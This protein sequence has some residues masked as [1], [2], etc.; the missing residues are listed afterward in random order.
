MSEDSHTE[1]QTTKKNT[2]KE[3]KAEMSFLDHLEA[4]R[5]HFIRSVI[6][7]FVFAIAAFIYKDFIF[8]SIIFAP[9]NPDFWTNRMF[10]LLADYVGVE[11]LKINSHEL[12]LISIAMSGQFMVHIWTA[13]VVGLIVASPFVI[14]QFWSFIK[15]ALYENER[16]HATGAV[17]YMSGLFIMG[18]LFGYYL[19][20]PLSID[21]LGAYSISDTVVNQINILSYISTVTSIVIAGGVVF[22]LPVIAFFLSK[23]GILTPGFMRKYR[24]HAIVVL[25]LVSAVITPP[26]VFSQIM[27]CIPLL[28][29][30]E[31]S[32]VISARVQ[33]A[34]ERRIDQI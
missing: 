17:I 14:Y 24:K 28:I 4:L 21:F 15:P 19:I 23:V 12:Q 34:N 27:V 3:P 2:K 1:K 22:E 26:D 18:I 7:I 20:V 32:I 29:L 9:K 8:D 30:Y 25:L 11:A 31:V 10:A 33:K 16:K 5:W 13:I 6:S